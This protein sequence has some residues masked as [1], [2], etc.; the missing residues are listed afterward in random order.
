MRRGFKARAERL[1][2]ETRRE[3]GL[4]STQQTDVMQL[5]EHVGATVRRA[6][7]LT[8]LSKLEELEALQP[9]AFSACTFHIRGK[10]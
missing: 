2:D 3:M 5:A 10:P 4:R 8:S 6:D 1:A 7:R 9:G